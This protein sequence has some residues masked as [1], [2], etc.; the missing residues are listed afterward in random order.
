MADRYWVGG[1]ANWDGT[2]GTKWATTSGGGGGAAVPTASDDVYFDAG[3]GTC[4]VT[5]TASATCL[6]LN[7]TSTNVTLAGSSAL[8]ISASATFA[9]GWTYTGAI[10]FNATTT[11]FTIT[12]NGTTLG[13]NIT[14]NGVG[15]GWTLADALNTSGAVTLTNG[16]LSDGGFTLTSASFLANNSNTRTITK[17]GNWTLTGTGTVW[18]TNPSTNLTL[19]VSGLTSATNSSATA[20][21]ISNGT[22][23][24]EVGSFA[25]TAG[26]G[27]VTVSSADGSAILTNL[28]FTGFTGTWKAAGIRIKGNLTLGAGMTMESGSN[29]TQMVG[30]SGIQTV[31]S[32][33]VTW[34]RQLVC[35]LSTGNGATIQ[36][37]DDIVSTISTASGVAAFFSSFDANDQDVTIV[38][39]NSNNTNA[40]TISMGSGL[41]TLSGTGAPWNVDSTNKTFNADTSTIKFTDS[42]ASTKT[43][44]GA[45]LTYNDVWFSG[46][47][48]GAFL[49]NGSNTFNDLKIDQDLTVKPAA[50]TTQ[51]LSTFTNGGASGHLVTLAS[52]TPGSQFTLVKT[53]ARV[54]ANYVSV[55]DSIGS[56]AHRWY[57][58]QGAVNAGNNTGWEWDRVYTGGGAQKRKQMLKDEEQEIQEL[59]DMLAPTIA[60]QFS[61]RTQ[62]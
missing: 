41:W 15:G 58:G 24:I 62:S 59:L 23:R 47:G 16:A 5:I 20:R 34:T 2:A 54:V 26:T 28:D 6:N 7:K 43:F 49:V 33:G 38:A 37:A 11:G 3:S 44:S 55:R 19:S 40:L 42:S 61:E 1:T 17:T 32:N 52:Q 13:S 14:F 10:T 39:F 18:S 9:T 31:T 21:T 51:T 48:T 30:T 29:Q 4:T 12:S 25:V 45:G 27:D 57:Y 50:G 36:L 46:T 53:G 56:P 35:G 22:S 60:E 8:A